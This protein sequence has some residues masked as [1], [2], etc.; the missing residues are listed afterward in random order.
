MTPSTVLTSSRRLTQ[1]AVGLLLFIGSSF[2]LAID[3]VYVGGSAKAAIKGYD[4]VSY[5]TEAEPVKGSKEFSTE[6]QG[7]TW[8]FSSSEN[9]QTFVANPE[10]YAPQYGG[11]CSYAV[12]R[13]TTASIKPKVFNIHDGKLYLNY[14]KGVQRRWLK[15]LKKGIKKADKNWPELLEK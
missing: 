7:A 11:Y 13:N 3:A 12:S 9:L 1:F 2:A 8:L 10:K 4:T 14:N 15:D 6:Y 5:F